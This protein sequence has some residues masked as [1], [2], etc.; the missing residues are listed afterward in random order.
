M[1]INERVFTF[2]CEGETLVGVATLPGAPAPRG[3]LIVVGGPQ[4]RV[5]SH[6]QFVQLARA[7][8][9]EGVPVMRF[10]YRGMGDSTGAQRSFEHVN[11]DI[12]CALDHFC[13]VAPGVKEVVIWGLCDAASAALFY[14]HADSRVSG[15]VL[16]N[17]WVHTEQGTARVF[18]RHYYAQRLFQADLWRKIGSGDFNIRKAVRGFKDVVAGALGRA[19]SPGAVQ[20]GVAEGT[21]AAGTAVRLLPA[22]MQDAFGRFRGPVLLFLSGKDF[23]A[24]EFKDLIAGSRRWRRLLAMSRVAR[25]D[26]AEANH[27]FSRRTWRDEVARI[28]QRWLS[29]L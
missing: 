3:V 10:D 8:A 25:H 19:V 12:R 9:D 13:Q 28:T 11:A 7:L 21:P 22:R 6:R 5:G 17:P 18:L 29:S 1:T 23:T 15:L 26:M 24:Q 20:A 16:L 27:T 4:Y 2:D 14:A